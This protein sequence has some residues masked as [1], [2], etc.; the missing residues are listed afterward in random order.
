M[1]RQ[2]LQGRRPAYPIVKAVP[3]D[4]Y[5]LHD[6]LQVGLLSIQMMRLETRA[7]AARRVQTRRDAVQIL[8]GC[9]GE[10]TR[11]NAANT[12]M[13]LHVSTRGMQRA[14]VTVRVNQDDGISWIKRKVPLTDVRGRPVSGMRYCG[15]KNNNIYSS[16]CTWLEQQGPCFGAECSSRYKTCREKDERRDKCFAA[17]YP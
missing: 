2:E 14:R 3:R 16:G 15:D 1:A 11:A 10:I 8:D 7:A 13:Q 12:K 17:K 9:V 4:I 6:V 5:L